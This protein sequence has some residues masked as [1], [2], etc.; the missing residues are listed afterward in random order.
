VLRLPAVAGRFYPADPA[1]LT[2]QIAAFASPTEEPPRRAMACVVP[3]AGYRYSGHVAGAVYARLK[4]PRRFLLLGPRHFPRGKNQAIVS[5]GAWQTPLGC[6]EIDSELAHELRQ[7][8]PEL[9]EDD[10]AHQTEHALEVQLPFLQSLSSDFRFVPIALGVT[11]YVQLESLGRAL[12]EVLRR[13][14]DP[15]LMIASSDMNHYESDEVTRRKD[16]LAL[17]PLLA[18]NAHGLFDTVRHESIT[19][20][21]FG[22]VVSVLTA[23]RLLG[24]ARATL[25]RYATS[26]DVSGDRDEVVGYAGVIVE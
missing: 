9:C 17:E 20:C 22:P 13:Q 10:V 5:D 7:A 15:V 8:Y 25:V 21:G 19:M 18:L 24:A 23:A 6:A 12:A 14:S 16:R 3:H 26:G 1:E 11:D 4:L 2:R